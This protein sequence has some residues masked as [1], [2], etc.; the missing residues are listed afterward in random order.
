[1]A[2]IKK[3]K[4]KGWQRCGEVGIPVPYWWECEMIQSYRKVPQKIKIEL[5]H[6]LIIPL[7]GIYL[8][9]VKSVSQR[10]VCT[11][12]SIVALFTAAKMCKQPRCP[13]VN[14]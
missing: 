6:D 7:L 1:M 10:D 12:T 9:E 3:T 13:S 8:K 11:H 14:K 5:P 2:I 4:E